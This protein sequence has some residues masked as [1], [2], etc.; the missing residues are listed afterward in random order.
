MLFFKELPYRELDLLDFKIH[1][2]SYDANYPN[3]DDLER[4][5]LETLNHETIIFATPV[6]WYAMSGIMKSFFDRLTDLVTVK[7]ELGRRFK[8]KSVFFIAVGTDPSLPLGFDIPFSLTAQY[9]DM[10]F[11]G[12]IYFSTNEIDEFSCPNSELSE[13]IDKVKL[14]LV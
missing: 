13:F 9:F 4:V 1:T 11:L 3:D 14:S 2:Y 6:Y 5:I 8:G 12:G 7:K 10:D